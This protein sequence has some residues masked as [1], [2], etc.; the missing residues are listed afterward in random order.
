MSQRKPLLFLTLIVAIV[1]LLSTTQAN[2]GVPC[3][4]DELNAST[5]FENLSQECVPLK[6]GPQS[7]NPYTSR[8]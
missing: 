5:C 8:S 1:A 3:T 4:A 6:A 7:E 2:A